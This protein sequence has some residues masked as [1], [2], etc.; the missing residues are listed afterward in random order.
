MRYFSNKFVANEFL[1]YKIFKN[2]PITKDD[3]LFLQE[4]AAFCREMKLMFTDFEMMVDSDESYQEIDLTQ[5]INNVFSESNDVEDSE[6]VK[7]ASYIP[8]M[9]PLKNNVD[10][11]SYIG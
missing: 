4:F 7:P 2:E 11:V 6:P 3:I 8:P 10:E 9:T 5:Y 1:N